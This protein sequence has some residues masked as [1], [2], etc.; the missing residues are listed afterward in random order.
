[1]VCMC[2]KNI[3]GKGIPQT[4]QVFPAPRGMKPKA[5]KN[6]KMTNL[7]PRM[8]VSCRVRPMMRARCIYKNNIFLV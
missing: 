3:F 5:H 7:K 4:W 1:M 6:K 2:I 8:C